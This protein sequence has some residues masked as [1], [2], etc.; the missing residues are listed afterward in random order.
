MLFSYYDRSK[1][2]RIDYKE[3]TQIFVEGGKTE[4]EFE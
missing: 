2:G 4:E 1:D 3:F